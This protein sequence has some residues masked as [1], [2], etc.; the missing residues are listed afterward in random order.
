MI[1]LSCLTYIQSVNWL[2]EQ[3]EIIAIFRYNLSCDQKTRSFGCVAL[4]TEKEKRGSASGVTPRKT[5]SMSTRKTILRPGFGA[6]N[7]SDTRHSFE[8]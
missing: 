2:Q 7:S 5:N 6:K 8:G 1:H 4:M 3:D